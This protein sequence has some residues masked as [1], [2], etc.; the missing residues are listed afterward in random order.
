M[1]AAYVSIPFDVR[2]VYGTNGQ[3]KVKAAFDGH[4]YQGSLANMGTGSH[5]LILRKDIRRAIGKTVGD[6]VEVVLVRDQQEREVLVP[7]DLLEVL[8]SQPAALRFYESLSYTNRKEYVTWVTSAKKRAT[9]SR[10]IDGT[11]E[12]LLAGMKNPYQK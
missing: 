12:K 2:K 6:T 5:I 4:P 11:L 9:R 8:Q 7:E 1:D 10:R 3:V